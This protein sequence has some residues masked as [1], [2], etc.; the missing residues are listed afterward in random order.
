M[1]E[2]GETWGLHSNGCTAFRIEEEL[3]GRYLKEWEVYSG[4][5]S[6]YTHHTTSKT[7]PVSDIFHNVTTELPSLSVSLA[8]IYQ[9]SMPTQLPLR[10]NA[11]SKPLM[12]S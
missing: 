5:S 1:W 2:N 9:L 7:Q 11:T 3:F 6:Y 10:V 12:L 4:I 8:T